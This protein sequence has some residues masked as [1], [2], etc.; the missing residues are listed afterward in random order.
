MLVCLVVFAF[1]TVEVSISLGLAKTNI[2][3]ETQLSSIRFGD[4]VSLVVMRSKLGN[5]LIGHVEPMVCFGIGVRQSSE[6]KVGLSPKGP[7][8][9][10]Q[11]D[12]DQRSS[13]PV[14]R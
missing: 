6:Q 12:R 1:Q 5:G 8:F 13:E 9:R 2:L 10:D 4:S 7:A 3:Q 11:A 14:P